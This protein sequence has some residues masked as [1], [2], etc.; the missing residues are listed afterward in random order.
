AT[1]APAAAWTPHPTATRA[2]G[3]DRQEHRLSSAS[4][5]LFL[6]VSILALRWRA[7]AAGGDGSDMNGIGN[8]TRRSIVITGASSGIGRATAM[9]LVRSGWR[10]FA[11]VRR[12]GDA[13]TIRGE[14]GGAV[15]TVQLDVVDKDS[16]AAAARDIATRLVAAVSMLCSTTP[17]S[18]TSFRRSTVRSKRS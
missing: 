3:H 13:T 6:F 18:A 9:R 2:P 16:I 14:T 7:T 10:V 1:K 5:A 15:E 12:E 4:L 17:G 11:T 8:G